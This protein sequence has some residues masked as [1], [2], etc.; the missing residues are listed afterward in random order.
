MLAIAELEFLAPGEGFR[1][2]HMDVLRRLQID[3]DDGPEHGMGDGK[4]DHQPQAGLGIAGASRK[5]RRQP[6]DATACGARAKSRAKT[7]QLDMAR[8]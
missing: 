8:A 5:P 7:M 6:P 1:D 2:I 3:Q 4:A